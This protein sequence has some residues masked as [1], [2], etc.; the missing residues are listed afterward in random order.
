MTIFRQRARH[1][2]ERST[3]ISESVHSIV[4]TSGNRINQSPKGGRL[5]AHT[6][7]DI[8]TLF[9]I[10]AAKYSRHIIH[11]GNADGVCPKAVGVGIAQNRG[12][13]SETENHGTG[14]LGD[15]CRDGRTVCIGHW[16]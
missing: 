7:I 9:I 5:V 15:G 3:R 8:V 14:R 4:S 11:K 12:G 10:T 1:G 6:R 2:G 16:E 13:G